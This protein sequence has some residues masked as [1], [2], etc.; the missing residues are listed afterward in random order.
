[1]KI[2]PPESNRRIL[3]VDDNRPIPGDFLKILAGLP[4]AFGRWPARALAV[5]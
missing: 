5:A 4:A 1:M 3:I 2:S